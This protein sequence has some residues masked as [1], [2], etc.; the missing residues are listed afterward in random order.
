MEKTVLIYDSEHPGKKPFRVL[1]SSLPKLQRKHGNR[2]RLYDEVG[3]TAEIE[4]VK[5]KKKAVAEGEGGQY[6][7]PKIDIEVTQ[8][9]PEETETSDKK[10]KKK[11]PKKKSVKKAE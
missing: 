3:S 2:Y 11:K 4:I 8:E 7:P 10:P 6:T 1:E 5:P 9:Q